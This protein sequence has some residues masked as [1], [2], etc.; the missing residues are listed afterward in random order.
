MSI[1][2]GMFVVH[3]IYDALGGRNDMEL[4]ELNSISRKSV[5]PVSV[6]CTRVT[7]GYEALPDPVLE[8]LSVSFDA[9]SIHAIVGPSGSG[10]STLINGVLGIQPILSGEVRIAGINSDTTVLHDEL[11]PFDWM[12]SVGYLSQMPFLFRGTVRENL[13]MMRPNQK[14]DEDLVM[15]LVQ[16]LDMSDALG[17]DPLEFILSEGGTSLSGGQQ[18]RLALIR[19][20]QFKRPVFIL[21]EATSALDEAMRDV[22]F[23]ILQERAEEGACIILVTH[24]KA[25]AA[26]CDSV[27]NLEDFQRN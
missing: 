22:V 5:K 17:A 4:R 21:D 3:V 9:G 25:V 27:L 14:V 11:D 23:G 6:V 13:T 10:K 24:D 26:Q 20:L 1:R 16:R 7:L 18:Q 15:E 12:C 8:D 2:R 19:A